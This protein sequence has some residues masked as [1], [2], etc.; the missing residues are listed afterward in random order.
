MKRLISIG[1]V[2]LLAAGCGSQKFYTYHLQNLPD[3]EPGTIYLETTG[4]GKS[5]DDAWNNA[6]KQAFSAV[7]FKGIPG[8]VQPAPMVDDETR[9]MAEHK[10][11]VEC[12]SNF[13]CYSRFISA[14]EKVDVPQQLKDGISVDLKIKIN[15]RTLRAYLEENQVIRHFGL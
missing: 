11:T 3:T 5:E 2:A 10:Q 9:A 1:L 8:S 15:L 14:S 6:A 4:L 13:N 12:F 7:L